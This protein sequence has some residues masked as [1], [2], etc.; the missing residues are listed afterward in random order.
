MVNK[1]NAVELDLI[2]R[3]LF[4]LQQLQPSESA[5]IQQ[6]I[7]KM[8]NTVYQVEEKNGKF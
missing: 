8:A 4:A 6:L 2:V 1:F 3:G 5:A 7:N